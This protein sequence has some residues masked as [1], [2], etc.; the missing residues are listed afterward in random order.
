MGKI[1]Y[2]GAIPENPGL[3]LRENRLRLGLTQEELS[4]GFCS[5]SRYSRIE[6]GKELPNVEE[7]KYFM[8][9]LRERSIAMG[10]SYYCP[11][12]ESDGFIERH[13][14]ILKLW[15]ESRLDL[16]EKTG[17]L[18]SLYQHRFISS[19][20]AEIQLISFF[21]LMHNC[22]TCDS[23]TGLTLSKAAL[24]VLQITRPQFGLDNSHVNFLPSSI[25]FLL[26][27]AIACGMFESRQE[28]LYRSALLLLSDL[29]HVATQ[30]RDCFQSNDLLAALMINL[31]FF[32]AYHD[33]LGEAG[34]H[35]EM[36]P[37]FFT[38]S[39]GIYL[40]CKSLRCGYFFYKK[41]GMTEKCEETLSTI[42]IML[43]K[44]PSP[45]SVSFFM[46]NSPKIM[47]F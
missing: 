13:S 41:C 46:K 2:S 40:Y 16:W 34:R 8:N 28:I 25:E 10:E 29:I 21:E 1:Y 37:A 9:L 47:V 26:L 4:Y 11:E 33:D 35:L 14:I 6:S 17:D 39:G 7:F 20:S 24:D 42:R 27:N 19:L 23:F 31:C 18:V 44:I 36:I 30:K 3:M 38:T 43:E 22:H 45:P 32:E 5:T 12:E 15:N